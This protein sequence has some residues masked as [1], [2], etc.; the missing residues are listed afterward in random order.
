MDSTALA[1]IMND[2]C[3]YI[4]SSRLM[5]NPDDLTDHYRH[6]HINSL[7]IELFSLGM[8]SFK[9]QENNLFW[10]N[11]W[12]SLPD[13][14][15]LIGCL[16]L[17]EHLFW[18]GRHNHLPVWCQKAMIY[19]SCAIQPVMPRKLHDHLTD[20]DIT[21][22]GI[23][24]IYGYLKEL[25]DCLYN[26]LVLMFAPGVVSTDSDMKLSPDILNRVALYAKNH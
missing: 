25:P 6:Y 1:R 22:E 26:R 9:L 24:Q 20:D 7:I 19:L 18:R 5:L 4:Y 21:S 12:Y 23:C 10:L 13:I 3:S 16:A 8:E 11:H 15:F 2:P 17:R 14:V